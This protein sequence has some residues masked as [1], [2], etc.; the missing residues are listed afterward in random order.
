MRLAFHHAL[1]TAPQPLIAEVKPRSPKTGVLMGDLT[2]AE[3]AETYGEAGVR[4]LSV[5]TGRWHGGTPAMIA[6]LAQTGLPVLRKDFIASR[7][8]LEQSRDLGASAVLLTCTLLRP[9]DIARLADAAL[10]LGLTPFV[11]VATAGELQDLTLPPEAILAIN[12]RNIRA[13]ETDD[14]GI[15]R[16][17]NLLAPARDQHAGLLVSASGLLVASDVQLVREAGF[18]GVL[19]GTALLGSGADIA[20]TTRQFL[21]AAE[22]T[23]ANA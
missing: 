15:S 3:V 9:K 1:A 6:T 2:V 21:Q 18:D 11:E 13:Q 4:C 8:H 17:L 12:N 7:A 16:S 19:V 10:M 14:G 20:A 23:P 5:T 22:R